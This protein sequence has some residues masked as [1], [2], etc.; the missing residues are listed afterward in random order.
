M[1]QHTLQERFKDI[2]QKL[3]KATAD[4]PMVSVLISAL[5]TLFETQNNQLEAQSIQ[6]KEQK[7]LIETLNC[8]IEELTAKLGNFSATDKY[9]Y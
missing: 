1:S 8:A 6:L 9:H 3:E 5:C 2:S 7:I 4:N